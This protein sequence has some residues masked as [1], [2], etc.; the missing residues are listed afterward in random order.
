MLDDLGSGHSGDDDN[1]SE[2]TVSATDV[3]SALPSS[4]HDDSVTSVLNSLYTATI[5][6]HSK[7]SKVEVD[8]AENTGTSANT[9]E[10]TGTISS[11]PFSSFASPQ[12]LVSKPPLPQRSGTLTP[13]DMTRPRHIKTHRRSRSLQHFTPTPS[14][15]SLSAD[16][17]TASAVDS[18]SSPSTTQSS[19]TGNVQNTTTHEIF[20]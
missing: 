4:V 13:H 18:N 20:V 16:S 7:L 17:Q 10:N 14:I 5:D 12:K 2:A 8:T 19:T 3:D 15:V 1:V 9:A 6:D 11:L